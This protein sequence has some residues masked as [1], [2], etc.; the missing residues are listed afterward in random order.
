MSA[1][2]LAY[3]DRAWADEHAKRCTPEATAC[4]TAP[5]EFSRDFGFD[6]IGFDTG[7]V[8]SGSPLQVHLYAQLFAETHVAMGGHL[9]TTWPGPT[10]PIGLTFA[11]P[12]EPGT[13]ALSF[14]YGVNIGAKAKVQ[15][16]VLG[17]SYSWTGDIPYLP[18]F[19]YHVQAQDTF[20][21]WAFDGFTVDGSTTQ[22]TLAQVSVTDF[23]GISIPGLDGGFELDSYTELKATYKTLRMLVER[24]DGTVV[25]G[26][27]ILAESATTFEHGDA[28]LGGHV[29]V[30]VHPEGEVRYDVVLHM[31][32]A[33]YIDTIG[34]SFSIPIAD[35]PIPFTLTQDDWSFDPVRVRVPLPDIT[36][37]GDPVD[38]LP[39]ELAIT[40]ED[41]DD[42]DETPASAGFS[43]ANDG[44][45][46]LV[47][48]LSV[49]GPFTA[50][51]GLAELGIGSA[52][53]VTVLV[54]TDEPGDHTGTLT[55]ASNDPDEPARV[56]KLSA[57]VDAFIPP[58]LEEEDANAF[59]KAMAAGGCLCS[60][61]HEPADAGLLVALAGVAVV[62]ARRRRRATR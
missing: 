32:P 17:I 35:I 62:A 50:T 54:D 30:D 31:I 52:T 22:Q 28:P 33:F 15:I 42:D 23:I 34:P 14:H 3:T 6:P 29:E 37:E 53:S 19:D 12:G 5:L 27:P 46:R 36:L 39:G 56:V 21:P 1:L 47:S 55:I 10:A 26:G 48:T 18:Q 57:H 45:E 43:V 44:E 38:A 8:P 61:A 20:D 4:M 60:A 51:I 9:R 11:T 58:P 49:D 16:S 59:S 25:E 40:L 24:P 41:A 13:G 7:W 2:A